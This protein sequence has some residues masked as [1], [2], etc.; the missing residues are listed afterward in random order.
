M[1]NQGSASAPTL[2]K[3]VGDAMKEQGLTQTTLA[4]RANVSQSLISNILGG[5]NRSYK[6]DTLARIADAIGINRTKVLTVAVN[7]PEEDPKKI[8]VEL[9]RLLTLVPQ[10]SVDEKR[11]L[12]SFLQINLRIDEIVAEKQHL[13][14]LLR[15]SFD[16]QE[17]DPDG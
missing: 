15:N 2:A 7:G 9:A 8:N 12:V 4:N 16:V 10:L 14:A 13:E 5:A 11:R 17:V 3:L 6:A 1:E